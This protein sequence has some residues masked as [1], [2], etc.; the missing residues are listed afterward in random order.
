[1]LICMMNYS[2]NFNKFQKIMAVQN[3]I[4]LLFLLQKQF[5]ILQNNITN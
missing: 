1:M 2:N 4:S 3:F 5:P